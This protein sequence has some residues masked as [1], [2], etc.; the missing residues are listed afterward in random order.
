MGVL[1]NTGL[2]TTTDAQAYV[3]VASLR[4]ECHARNMRLLASLHDDKHAAVLLA[5]ME[6]DA[7]MGRMSQ[8]C[9]VDDLD[10]SQNLLMRRFAVEQGLCEDGSVN[11]RAVDDATASGTNGSCSASEKLSN[12]R[13][14][15][16]AA[17][18][19]LFYAALGCV[20]ALMKCDIDAAFR[21][22]PVKPDHR[23]L[24]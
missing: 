2:G 1:D 11:V 22:I 12:D 5:K 21:R 15:K 24:V 18:A 6:Q 3:D 14:D 9:N 20:P 16:L 13:Y 17:V 10:L 4:E 7:A 23:W 19:Q 8:P